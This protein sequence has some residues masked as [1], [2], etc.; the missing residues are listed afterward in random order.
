MLSRQGFDLFGGKQFLHQQ[1][2]RREQKAATVPDQLLSHRA[3]DMGFPSTRRSEHQNVLPAIHKVPAEQSPQLLHRFA[4]QPLQVQRRPILLHGQ[5]RFLQQAVD[6]PLP[7][8]LAFPFQQFQQVLRITPGLGTGLPGHRLV[9]AP[10]RRQVQLLQARRQRLR[11][12]LAHDS[13]PFH[14]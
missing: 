11:H 1:R 10:H 8:L 6:P 9:L 14:D 12:I 2:R 5:P 3:Q 7:S 13:P 4:R